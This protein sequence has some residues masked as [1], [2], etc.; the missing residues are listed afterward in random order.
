M[1]KALNALP[2]QPVRR[3]PSL[4]VPAP[5]PESVPLAAPRTKEAQASFTRS[6]LV[7][8]FV[9]AGVGLVALRACG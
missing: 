3:N 9:L 1:L 2:P 4:P 5:P 7:I 6:W 8:A